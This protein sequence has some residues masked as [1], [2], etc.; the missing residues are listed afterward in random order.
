MFAIFVAVQESGLFCIC[1]GF[2][3]YWIPHY[4]IP[5]YWILNRSLLDLCVIVLA[6]THSTGQVL[7]VH[8]YTAYCSLYSIPLVLVYIQY[9]TNAL[10]G[11]ACPSY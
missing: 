4:W 9:R 8:C 6:R 1:A 7:E 3:Q 2:P 5:P 10:T 11:S